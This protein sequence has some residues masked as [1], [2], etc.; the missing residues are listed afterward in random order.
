MSIEPEFDIVGALHLFPKGTVAGPLGPFRWMLQASPC[1]PPYVQGHFEPSCIGPVVDPGWGGG[2]VSG[3]QGH[4]PLSFSNYIF[5]AAQYSV[6]NC[7][8]NV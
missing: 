8:L 7:I 6:F 5:I 1:P 2:G 4:V 3:H